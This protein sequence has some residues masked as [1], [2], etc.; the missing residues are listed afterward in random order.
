MG[1]TS[2]VTFLYIVGTR[3]GAVGTGTEGRQHLGKTQ[4]GKAKE[5]LQGE[6]EP[7]PELLSSVHPRHHAHSRHS[8]TSF[9]N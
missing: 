9:V 8:C 3:V 4:R 5:S 2:R 7:T 6:Q 1:G